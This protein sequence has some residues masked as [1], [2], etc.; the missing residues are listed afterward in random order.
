M[1]DSDSQL[2]LPSS[3]RRDH[4]G[5]PNK[6]LWS[7]KSTRGVPRS[8]RSKSEPNYSVDKMKSGRGHVR[9]VATATRGKVSPS[10]GNPNFEEFAPSPAAEFTHA[11]SLPPSIHAQTCYTGCIVEEDSDNQRSD[12]VCGV[13]QR[14]VV[15]SMVSPDRKS[16]SLPGRQQSEHA[17][18]NSHKR[19]GA[20]GAPGQTNA[21]AVA[22]SCFREH[23]SHEFHRG[24]FKEEK[25]MGASPPLPAGNDSREDGW[26]YRDRPG[27]LTSNSAV[28]S[29]LQSRA[30]FEES[31]PS[32]S[33]INRNYERTF[34]GSKLW[35]PP[36]PPRGQDIVP[37]QVFGPVGDLMDHPSTT[38]PPLSDAGDCTS[39]SMSY[40]A[41]TSS[42]A[43]ARRRTFESDDSFDSN[44]ISFTADIECLPRP[45]P[46]NTPSWIPSSTADS[47]FE[48]TAC[49]SND[50][51]GVAGCR[52]HHKLLR[53]FAEMRHAQPASARA[54]AG[55]THSI[56]SRTP[57]GQH[58][59]TRP[60]FIR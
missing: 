19:V 23:R 16:T 59:T 46:S 7:P 42:A 9:S 5:A 26:G 12:I 58:V 41:E 15:P 29:S 3:C 20:R 47:S 38:P 51:V 32:S 54:D 50:R 55:A 40:S 39:C 1:D 28:A 21:G 52:T 49:P 31:G 13:Y 2:P 17:T 57:A 37:G 60:I 24:A 35:T 8:Q 43:P 44:E 11:K 48:Y 22:A 36:L 56:G 34:E 25:C 53:S 10:P 4:L 33:L 45:H 14:A 30:G 6:R 18:P 27:T